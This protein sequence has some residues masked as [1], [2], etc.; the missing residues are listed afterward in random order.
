MA[1]SEIHKPFIRIY[2]VGG[3][4]GLFGILF[5]MFSVR[6]MPGSLAFPMVGI[7]I[8]FCGFFLAL[9]NILLHAR[10]IRENR[11]GVWHS[12]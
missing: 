1:V 12:C 4:V 7:L 3:T 8:A 5:V 11:P 10:E 2:T 6:M 9:F